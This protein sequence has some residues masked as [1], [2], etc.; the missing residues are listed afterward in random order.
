[1]SGLS[2]VPT[3]LGMNWCLLYRKLGGHQDRSGLIPKPSLP[4]EFDPQTVKPIVSRCIDYAIQAHDIVE[5]QVI[6]KMMIKK[7][8]N[9]GNF[10]S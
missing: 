8:S 9:V 6:K 2:H 1:V 10:C 4:P 3:T 5:D 7:I